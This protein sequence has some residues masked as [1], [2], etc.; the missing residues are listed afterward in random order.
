[1]SNVKAKI[2]KILIPFK[3]SNEFEDVASLNEFLKVCDLT[4]DSIKE[5]LPIPAST[6]AL[7]I[8]LSHHAAYSFPTLSN[9]SIKTLLLCWQL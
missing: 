4:S 5:V 6:R 2:T 7:P 9:L 8:S 1:L 3:L